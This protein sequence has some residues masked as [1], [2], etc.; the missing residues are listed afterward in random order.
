MHDQSGSTDSGLWRPGRATK[1]FAC[2]IGGLVAVISAWRSDEYAYWGLGLMAALAL[3]IPVLQFRKFW[4][5]RKFWIAVSGLVVL[6]VPLVVAA[7]P[8][9][10]RLGAAFPLEFGI[11][12]GQFVIIVILLLCLAP[13]RKGN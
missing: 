2:A 13:T 12:D 5:Q 11:A 7:Q 1:A 3:V 10:E 4:S 6:Q 8:L 9:I